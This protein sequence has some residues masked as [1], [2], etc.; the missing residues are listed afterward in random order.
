M[1][2]NA[3][4]SRIP[5]LVQIIQGAACMF[6]SRLVKLCADLDRARHWLN[7]AG[8]HNGFAGG[9]LGFKLHPALVEIALLWNK[10]VPDTLVLD[11][12][13]TIRSS[14]AAILNGI[15]A[16]RSDHLAAIALNAEQIDVEHARCAENRWSSAVCSS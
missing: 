11:H 12:D 4:N 3:S 7:A 15:A 5:H 16:Q 9:I 10:V 13:A 14:P 2:L 8:V 6:T 1:L